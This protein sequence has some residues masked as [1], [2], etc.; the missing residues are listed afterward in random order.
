VAVPVP[1]GFAI[2]LPYGADVDWA[3]NLQAADGGVLVVKGQRHVV[4]AVR[5]VPT[6]DIESVLPS[7]WRRL[8]KLSTDNGQW[9]LVHREH[10][11]Q[12]MAARPARR[13]SGT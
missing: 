12:T 2:P 13:G 11:G 10:P 9:L 8:S 6:R 4:N 5:A 1:A 7:R 3:R